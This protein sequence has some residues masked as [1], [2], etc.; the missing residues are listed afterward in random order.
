MLIS[1]EEG[2]AAGL[3]G[4]DLG[5]VDGLALE[6]GGELGAVEEDAGGGDDGAQ[7]V[8][9][10]AADAGLRAGADGALKGAV[11]LGVVAVGAEGDVSGGG[12]AV[13]EVG[14]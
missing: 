11:L 5:Q 4:L 14:R 6:A 7:L 9:G 12:G 2:S 13:A 3:D 1:T 8:A 10:G